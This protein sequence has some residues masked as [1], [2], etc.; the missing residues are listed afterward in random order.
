MDNE[1]VKAL[2]RKRLYGVE[3]RALSFLTAA[4]KSAL[5]KIEPSRI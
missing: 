3:Q 4:G 5:Q 1:G 2:V